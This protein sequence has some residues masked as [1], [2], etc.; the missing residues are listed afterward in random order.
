MDVLDQYAR[1]EANELYEL[2]DY[3]R[4]AG[5]AQEFIDRAWENSSKNAV[6]CGYIAGAID[7]LY[8]AGKLT[9]AEYTRLYRIVGL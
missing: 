4:N 3:L 9:Q 5:S 7:A 6:A 2:K 8:F 1:Y